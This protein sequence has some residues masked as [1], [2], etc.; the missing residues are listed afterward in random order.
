MRGNKGNEREEKILEQHKGNYNVQSFK[1]KSCKNALRWG[2]SGDKLVSSPKAITHVCSASPELMQVC[3]PHPPL[4]VVQPEFGLLLWSF[5]AAPVRPYYLRGS[6]QKTALR[7]RAQVWSFL[8]G[9]YVYGRRPRSCS[10]QADFFPR[11]VPLHWFTNSL[12]SDTTLSTSQIS[13]GSAAVQRSFLWNI[14]TCMSGQW[15]DSLVH[16]YSVQ[17][18]SQCD[19][20]FYLLKLLSILCVEKLQT[21]LV[22]LK[23]LIVFWQKLVLQN[24][25]ANFSSL[26]AFWYL[27]SSLYLS[28]LFYLS[29]YIKINTKWIKNPQCQI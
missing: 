5:V 28:L 9:P 25:R 20:Y 14:Y 26:T 11:I 7:F 29:P 17:W 27:L 10:I 12:M 16:R 4:V 6:A 19:L 22:I 3:T 24:I 13:L 2:R 21:L 15:Q 1:A 18:S 8:S 23:Y